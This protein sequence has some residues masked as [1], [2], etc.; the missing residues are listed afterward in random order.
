MLT[1]VFLPIILTVV[2]TVFPGTTF[3]Q[4]EGDLCWVT[5]QGQETEIYVSNDNGWCKYEVE[6][7]E[8]FTVSVLDANGQMV[9]KTFTADSEPQEY[10]VLP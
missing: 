8:T 1:T 6:A 10:N 9:S 5:P 2:T 7:G 4:H 3:T